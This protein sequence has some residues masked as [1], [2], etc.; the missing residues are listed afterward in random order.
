MIKRHLIT[1]IDWKTSAMTAAL[2]LTCFFWGNS[3]WIYTKAHLANILIANAWRQTL[4][5]QDT[6]KPWGWADTWPVA[7]II[8]PQQKKQF[9]ILSGAH[10]TSL[11][12]SPGHIDGTANFESIGTKII[13]GHRDTH[14]DFIEALNINDSIH[15]QD[16]FGQWQHY[17]VTSTKIKDIRDGKWAYEPTANE[18][19]MITCY[20]FDDFIP[21]GP[22]R[23]V[24]VARAAKDVN[25]QNFTSMTF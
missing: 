23:Y 19:H 24:V 9:F 4:Q 11:A 22:L 10:G 1:L 16:K 21:G 8:F 20:P 7:K 13:G 25:E 18:L 5:T 14:F 17:V 3:A 12:F 6:I 2:T 15:V